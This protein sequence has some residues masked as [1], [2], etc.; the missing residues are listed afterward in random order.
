MRPTPDASIGR[1]SPGLAPQPLRSVLR[2]AGQRQF[3]TLM[4]DVRCSS[5]RS[6]A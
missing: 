3:L 4:S 2:F 6:A 5:V 1:T